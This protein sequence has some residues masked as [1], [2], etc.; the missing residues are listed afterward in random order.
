MRGGQKLMCRLSCCTVSGLAMLV[1]LVRSDL[2]VLLRQQRIFGLVC[3][4]LL[5]L[6]PIDRLADTSVTEMM[7]RW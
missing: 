6:G 7:E 2:A 4:A 5:Q 3:E 1:E